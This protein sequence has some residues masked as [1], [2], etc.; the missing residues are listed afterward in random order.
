MLNIIAGVFSEPTPPAPL[1]SYE[2]IATTTV[3]SGGTGTVTFS[4]IPGTF[5]HLQLRGIVRNTSA[6]S[7]INGVFAQFNSDTA[8][9]YSRH[10]LIG[11]GASA[12]ASASTSTTN[13]LAGQY[14]QGGTT[15]NIFGVFVLDILDYQNTNKNKTTR[16]LFGTDLN[17]SGQIRFNSGNWRDTSAIT[18]ITLTPEDA[19][20]VQ[21]S[22]FALYG[23]KG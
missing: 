6:G 16:G 2:S 17:G 12:T 15:A 4:S 7:S 11:D 1:T 3:G 23:I 21:Y 5:K 10:N 9:N 19:N 8:A 18:S 13:V 14:P 20:F 22:S